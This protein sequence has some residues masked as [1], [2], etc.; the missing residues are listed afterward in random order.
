MPCGRLREWLDTEASAFFQLKRLV[1]FSWNSGDKCRRQ[2]ACKLSLGLNTI[3]VPRPMT[4]QQSCVFPNCEVFWKCD[5][6]LHARF[7]MQAKTETLE[8]IY[9]SFTD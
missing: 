1:T 2:S 5:F 4:G 7:R 6:L 9:V 3:S 8:K